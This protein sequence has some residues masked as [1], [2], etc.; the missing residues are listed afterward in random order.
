MGS[1]IPAERAKMPVCDAVFTRIGAADD[2]S[3]GQSTFMV[4]M[5]ELAFILGRATA[6]SLI[7]LDEVGRGTGTTDGLAIAIATIEH[8]AERIG[9]KTLFATHY[10]ELVT[11]AEKTSGA[12]NLSMA[13]E[14]LGEDI[15]FLWKVAE[16]GADKSHGIFV[17]KMA[18]LPQNVIE[19]SQEI[20]E[21]LVLRGIFDEDML[22]ETRKVDYKDVQEK[23]RRYR[24]FLEEIG[25]MEL[26]DSDIQQ[27]LENMRKVKEKADSLI[28]D[29]D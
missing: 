22:Q 5:S 12:I 20:H 25:A 16:G 27:V 7:L 3:K 13:V 8:I 29:A 6:Q 4:E 1:F 24:L 17:A 15:K 18:G 26:D 10:H 19:R 23:I 21:K 9:A 14:A 2:I 11:A 28:S